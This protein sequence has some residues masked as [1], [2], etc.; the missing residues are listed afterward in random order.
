[1]GKDV[2]CEARPLSSEFHSKI[3]R[4]RRAR[5]AARARCVQLHQQPGEVSTERACSA[6]AAFGPG[7][8][9]TID[10]LEFRFAF[11]E[12]PM[13]GKLPTQPEPSD[14]LGAAHQSKRR[15]RRR[16]EWR[17]RLRRTLPARASVTSAGIDP[18]RW[19]SSRS[20]APTGDGG[21][22]LPPPSRKAICEAPCAARRCPM[23]AHPNTGERPRWEAS[24]A[25]RRQQSPPAGSWP[26]PPFRILIEED[27]VGERS[28]RK[29]LRRI[30]QAGTEAPNLRASCGSARETAA[31]L[32][33]PPEAQILAAPRYFPS[34]YALLIDLRAHQGEWQILGR[35]G[36]G[37][38][39][40][41][42][43]AR[44]HSSISNM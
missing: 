8:D 5:G 9:G 27:I 19:R 29:C 34:E 1:M 24:D 42:S 39:H 40:A 4:A 10:K 2:P 44:S 22:R 37:C 30:E 18:R 15:L 23:P 11:G 28:T 35:L 33:G 6:I 7:H 12:G 14:A 41:Q 36:Q 16:A 17:P 26:R 32:R 21:I 13:V 25:G 38:L 31:V 43:F 3:R 20:S